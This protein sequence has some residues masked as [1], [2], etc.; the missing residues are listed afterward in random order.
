[1]D[2]SL[3]EVDLGFVVNL[4]TLR[5]VLKAM[6]VNGRRWW[7]ASDPSDAIATH[8]V[9]IGH[10]DPGCVD[11]LNTLYFRVP[12]LNEE[13]TMAGTDKLTLMLA[14]S[15]V[16]ESCGLTSRS[17]H[18]RGA[19][20]GILV[21]PSDPLVNDPFSLN[22]AGGSSQFFTSVI[23]VHVNAGVAVC[24]NRMLR[25]PGDVTH[26]HALLRR[27]PVSLYESARFTGETLTLGFCWRE[28]I[29][30][31]HALRLTR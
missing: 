16:Y 29:R 3:D 24:L 14:I 1:M 9:T 12:V 23:Y 18:C 8:T 30:A 22:S 4:E 28:R 19:C 11:R 20:P 7:I 25:R 27:R 15:I 21:V 13:L 6:S 26:V 17:R 31:S 10:G 2:F 5:D